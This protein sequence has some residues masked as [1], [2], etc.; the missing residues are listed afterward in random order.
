M[1]GLAGGT[2]SEDIGKTGNGTGGGATNKY[3]QSGDDKN[4]N[5]AAYR[6]DL[7]YSDPKTGNR[8][9]LKTVVVQVLSK[10]HVWSGCISTLTDLTWQ[11]AKA[12]GAPYKTSGK[13]ENLAE[14]LEDGATIDGLYGKYN[15]HQLVDGITDTQEILDFIT[16]SGGFGMSGSDIQKPQDPDPGFL[17]SYGYRILIQKIQMFAS[18]T[19]ASYNN[20]SFWK[21]AA[22]RKDVASGDY[23]LLNKLGVDTTKTFQIVQSSGGRTSEIYTTRADIHISVGQNDM[24]DN[25]V[26]GKII[27]STDSS[28]WKA[29]AD[30][31]NGLGYNILWF[32]TA[33]FTGDYSIDAACQNCD[34]T[35]KENKSYIIQDTT[36]WTAIKNVLNVDFGDITEEIHN[37][38]YNKKYKT[39]CREEYKVSFPNENNRV[40][41][42]P[43]RYFTLN[44]SDEDL[45]REVDLMPDF[46]PVKVTRTRIC[47]EGN[48]NG[49]AA[50]SSISNEFKDT[51]EVYIKYHENIASAYNDNE[52]IHLKKYKAAGDDSSVS[53]SN[54]T[55]TMSTTNDHILYLKICIG[56]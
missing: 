28:Y 23:N 38:F 13:L 15:D 42:E 19:K 17:N 5:A 40:V 33:P 48:L 26:E 45:S 56:I 53:N 39:Y 29:F 6:F 1:T 22:T 54:G 37:Y 41:V 52:K 31:N 8:Q 20:C 44:A 32:S 30:W 4:I 3:W 2:G 10:V 43:G 46:R 12:V 51:G 35:D 50:D 34:S 25:S 18:G 7:V 36:D 11:Y 49:Y 9:I 21:F 16:S 47:K 27:N 55:L 14:K 24:Y